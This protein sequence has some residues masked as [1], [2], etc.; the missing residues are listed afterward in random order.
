MFGINLCWS[1]IASTPQIVNLSL[2]VN[3]S[4]LMKFFPLLR[5]LTLAVL[6]ITTTSLAMSLNLHAKGPDK[7]PAKGEAAPEFNL[8]VV[9]END[10]LSLK[11]AN[12]TGPVVVVVLRG[13]PGYQCP[14]C[15]QQVGALVNRAAAL[16]KLT[17]RVILVYPGEASMLDKHAE[18]FKGSRTLPAPL[19][20]VRDPA[21]KMVTAYNLRWTAPRET[22]YPAT[23]VIDKNGQVQWSKVSDSHSGRTNVEEILEQLRKLGR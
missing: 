8:P 6:A 10:F 5:G 16:E 23:F 2:L 14:L 17:K 13:F 7:G 19:I 22:A 18:E 11:D 20:M 3:P 9:G 12:A 1:T 4:S 15:S 21:M